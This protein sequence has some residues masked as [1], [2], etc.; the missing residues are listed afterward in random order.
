VLTAGLP[1]I[2]EGNRAPEVSKKSTVSA[3]RP[4]AGGTGVAEGAWGQTEFLVN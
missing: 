4:G 1:A 3:G 2:A